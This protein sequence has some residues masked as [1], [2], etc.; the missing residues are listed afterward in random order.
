[1]GKASASIVPD[2][3]SL[4]EM[5]VQAVPPASGDGIRPGGL[6][7][8]E[9]PEVPLGSFTADGLDT[10]FGNQVKSE[11]RRPDQFEK[12]AICI[13][14]VLETVLMVIRSGVKGYTTTYYFVEP[15][16]Q[17]DVASAMRAVVV[18]PWW[19]FR[20]RRWYLWVV[21]ASDDSSYWANMRPILEQP[22]AFYSGVS[23]TVSSE[24]A[25]ARYKFMKYAEARSW[26]GSPGRGTGVMLGQALGSKGFIRSTEHPVFKGLIE[27]EEVAL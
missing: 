15:A 9:V 21:N 18:I 8:M 7:P 24:K 6:Q 2:L 25:G 22:E 26:P 20:D 14:A 4:K 19:S 10:D 1:M 11:I 3:S 23:F 27:G 13:L 12:F 5:E 16:L 17:R